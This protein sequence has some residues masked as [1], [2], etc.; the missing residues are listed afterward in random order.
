M[1]KII[2]TLCIML[3]FA[4]N[5]MAQSGEEKNSRR[6][7]HKEFRERS[8]AYITKQVGFTQED[9]K[10]FFSLYNEMK[11]KQWEI[12]KEIIHLKKKDLGS[13][14]TE[15]EYN[16]IILEIKRLNVELAKV[17]EYYYKRMCKSI[18]ASKIYAA[19]KIEDDFHRHMLSKFNDTKGRKRP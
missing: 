7:N 8:E 16:D 14:A 1:K 3:T 10:V 9:A 17:E 18:P 2:Y 4:L 11:G 12:Q 19:M 15:K 13:N 6:F 5:V